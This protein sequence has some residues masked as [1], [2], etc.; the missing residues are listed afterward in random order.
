M[1]RLF[2]RFLRNDKLTAHRD[3]L[4]FSNVIVVDITDVLDLYFMHNKQVWD[5]SDPVTFPNL[6]PPFKQ[7]FLEGKIPSHM[8]VKGKL[9]DLHS[10]GYTGYLGC[11]VCSRRKYE[12]GR[13]VTEY[14]IFLEGLKDR[15]TFVCL[16]GLL[17]NPDGTLESGP[18]LAIPSYIASIEVPSS[19]QSLEALITSS[20]V[21]PM[22]LAVC[23]MN[24]NNIALTENNPPIK[25]SRK[26]LKRYGRPLTKY[27]TLDIEPMKQKS[28]SKDDPEADGLQK[29]LH[30]C[31]GHFKDFRNSKGLFGKYKG[32]YW[33]DQQVRGSKRNGEIVKD[34]KIKI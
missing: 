22:A 1:S 3:F 20:W 11:Y 2:D 24:C 30:I 21:M 17:I 14:H 18:S 33:W 7:S 32:L 31:R 5:L 6:I 34:Y 10:M 16:A 4:N 19:E 15:I 28:I 8:R 25:P 12:T 23:F 9:H 13:W 27:Y 26:H 29:S